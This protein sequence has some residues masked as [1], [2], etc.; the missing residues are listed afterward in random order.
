[1]AI[2][3]KDSKYFDTYIEY[4][5][6]LRTWLVAYGIGAPALILTNEKLTVKLLGNPDIKYFGIAF[7]S[8]VLLQVFLAFL[9]KTIMWC[10]YYGE[11]V[12]T[13]F[14]KTYRYQTAYLISS[15]YWIDIIIDVV[16]ICVFGYATL[17]LFKL[18]LP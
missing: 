13:D 10:C 5:K 9:N 11:E 8:G 1:M 17:G 18:L 16:T 12:D 3:P 4:A 14:Q 6:I 15:Q 7:L 2:K